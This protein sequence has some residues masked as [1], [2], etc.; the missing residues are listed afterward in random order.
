[1][2]E[3]EYLN[4]HFEV[5]EKIIKTVIQK[6]QKP[7]DKADIYSLMIPQYLV[8]FKYHEA[9]EAGIQAL[10]YI[11]LKIELDN[12]NK[13]INILREKFEKYNTEEDFEILY[14]IPDMKDAEKIVAIKILNNISPASYLAGKSDLYTLIAMKRIELS[15]EAGNHPFSSLGYVEYSLTLAASEKY[16]QAYKF[17]SLGFRLS[18]KWDMHSFFQKTSSC[19]VYAN[20]VYPWVKHMDGANRI[21]LDGY[22]AGLNSGNF[23]YASYILLNIPL[24]HFYQGKKLKDI[25]SKILDYL[26]F[27]EKNK[28]DL[29]TNSLMATGLAAQCLIDSENEI[30]NVKFHNITNSEYNESRLKSNDFWS[31]CL[32]E[33]LKA[34]VFY[35]LGMY[36]QAEKSILAAEAYLGYMPALTSIIST[37]AFFKALILLR[38]IKILKGKEKKKPGTLLMEP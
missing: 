8:T 25:Q 26:Q 33:T 3:L 10:H 29:S 28:E 17:G 38:K 9:I 19:Q 1:M 30:E 6:I 27:T 23:I 24:N 37:H 2:A 34:E 36:E 7:L 31:I 16:L 11:G 18:K 12:I 13:Q 20:F 14:N 5:S 22:E 15:H 32:I 35:I 4:G 21:N